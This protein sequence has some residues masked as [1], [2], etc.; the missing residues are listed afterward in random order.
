MPVL[1]GGIGIIAV[2]Q[3]RVLKITLKVRKQALGQGQF[4]SLRSAGLMCLQEAWASG[5]RHSTGQERGIAA[6]RDTD[7]LFSGSQS[8]EGIP[9]HPCHFLVEGP[10][11]NQSITSC[12][13]AHCYVA[14][15]PVTQQGNMFTRTHITPSDLCFSLQF[16]NESAHEEVLNQTTPQRQEGAA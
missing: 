8:Q 15:S 10:G 7:V 1:D 12:R 2:V 6:T 5:V 13:P 9:I 11:T 4:L 14:V 16:T 3:H